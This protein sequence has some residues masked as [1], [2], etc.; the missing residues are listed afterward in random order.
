MPSSA[1]GHFLTTE[2]LNSLPEPDIS[3]L[4]LNRLSRWQLLQRLH[5][6]FWK[7]WK[8]EYLNTLQQRSKRTVIYD[9]IKVNTLVLIKND[10]KPCLQ[11]ALGWV[12][13][14]HPGKDGHIRVVTVRTA[15]GQFL[16]PVISETPAKA[17]KART[18]RGLCTF[19]KIENS[20]TRDERVEGLKVIPSNVTHVRQALILSQ[21]MLPPVLAQSKRW[22]VIPAMISAWQHYLL[23]TIKA[24]VLLVMKHIK[25]APLATRK[26]R[27]EV[28]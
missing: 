12:V 20:K 3:H 18:N 17:P 23:F 19:T 25:H 7:R 21:H 8:S 11:W 4:S 9:N 27:A 13:Q 15:E 5:A 22:T 2:P 10:T 26:I 1:P 16:R 24:Q 14:L 6:D 28:F